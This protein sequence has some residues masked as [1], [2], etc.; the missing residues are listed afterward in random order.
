MNPQDQN[1]HYSSSGSLWLF[2]ALAFIPAWVIWF[3]SGVLPRAGTGVFDYRWL[4]AQIGVFA[5]SLA[6]LIVS[7]LSGQEARRN[8]FRAL[9]VL[10]LSLLIPGLLI[11]RQ[12]PAGVAD[13]GTLPA[14]ATVLVGAM[15]I[16]FFSP[17]NRRLLTPGTGETQAKP[18]PRWLVVS[19]VFFPALF[20]V[21]WFFANLQGGGWA[22]ATAQNGAAPF[23]WIVLVSFMHTLLLGG[24][25]GEELGWRGFLLPRLL[26]RHSPLAASLILAV[27]WALWHAPIDLTAGF[28]VQGPGALLAR[29]LWTLPVTILFTWLYL[30]CKGALLSALFLH[31]SMG[32]LSDLGFSAFPSSMLIYF[33]LLT[34]AAVIVSIMD[35]VLRAGHT[36]AQPRS[37]E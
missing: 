30:R 22:I 27:V 5:P 31:A 33:L 15:I 2:L 28:L 20:F 3:L 8:S 25:L 18:D 7:G 9:P 16:L 17:L 34:I 36:M 13:I 10:L 1:P 35:P 29:F 14:L 11:A 23:A 21:A 12:A 26:Q 37:F 19:V 24:P 32:L 4:F 6:A